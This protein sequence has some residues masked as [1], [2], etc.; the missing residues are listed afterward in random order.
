MPKNKEK[1]QKRWEA[2]KYKIDD[3]CTILNM[4]NKKVNQEEF[5]KSAEKFDRHIQKLIA[6]T[7]D[8]LGG[9]K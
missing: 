6:D 1:L 3:F 8:F 2:M 5:A 4:P 9:E 7:K